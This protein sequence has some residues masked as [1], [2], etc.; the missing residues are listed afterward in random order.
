MFHYLHTVTSS[1]LNIFQ[2]AVFCGK[3]FLRH[4]CPSRSSPHPTHPLHKHRRYSS[5]VP[6]PYLSSVFRRKG[7]QKNRLPAQQTHASVLNPSILWSQGFPPE[8]S[9]TRY[10]E[11]HTKGGKMLFFLLQFSHLWTPAAQFLL[12]SVATQTLTKS[13]TPRGLSHK[14]AR[15]WGMGGWSCHCCISHIRA[16]LLSSPFFSLFLF[17]VCRTPMLWW[18]GANLPPPHL[19]SPSHALSGRLQWNDCSVCSWLRPP[20]EKLCW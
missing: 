8:N 4:S 20:I 2:Q 17:S 10:A 1:L 18:Q 11:L 5:K 14:L 3:C 6:H 15:I 16:D 7:A 19:S 12:K 13:K 9:S